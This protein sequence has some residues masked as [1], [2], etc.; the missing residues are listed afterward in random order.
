MNKQE[1]LLSLKTK[2]KNFPPKEQEERLSFYSE[3]IDDR[4]EEGLSEEDAVAQ[5]GS[6]DKIATQILEEASATK[7]SGKTQPKPHKFTTFEIVALVLGSPLW[8]ALLVVAFATVFTIYASLCTTIISLWAVFGALIAYATA[9]LPMCLVCVFTNKAISGLAI[10][11]LG[12]VCAGL[13]IL[14]FY[15][16]K[17]ATKAIVFATKKITLFIKNSFIKKEIANE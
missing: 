2:L 17:W 1:F 3:M 16:C 15:G 6:V 9:S 11:A 7:Q 12:L 13:S 4:I 5:I 14:T 8:I 10:L